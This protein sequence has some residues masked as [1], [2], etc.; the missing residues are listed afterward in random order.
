MIDLNKIEDFFILDLANNHFGDLEHAK[1]VINSFGQIIKK[2]DIDATIKLQFRN[3]D[4]YIHKSVNVSNSE[5]KY[6]ERF[7]STKLNQ[8]DFALIIKEIKSFGLKT[9]ST[10][11]DEDSFSL[12][13][14]LDIDIIKIASTS[15]N[16]QSLLNE[17]KKTNKPCVISVGGKDIEQIDEIV[18]FFEGFTKN[19]IIQHCVAVYPTPD[20]ELEL[21]QISLLKKRYPLIKIGYSTHEDPNN[22]DAIKIAYALGAQC[23]ERHIGV[24]SEKYKLNNYSSNPSQFEN[25][26]L[27]YKKAKNLLGAKNKKPISNS[28]SETLKKLARGVYAKEKIHKNDKL[29]KN[30][31]YFSFPLNEGQLSSNEFD[32]MKYISSGNLYKDEI[33]KSSKLIFCDEFE[34]NDQIKKVMLQFKSMI[35]HSKTFINPDAD[36]EISH[37]YG[38]Q[39]FREFG[40]LI[41]TCFNFEYAKKL[42]LLLPRQKHP[43]H[44][45]K[46]KKE[47]FQIL[48]GDL[49]AEVDGNRVNL[50]PGEICTVK[51]NQWH[52]FQTSNGVIFEEV[53]S[54]HY[55]NDSYYKDE[56]IAKMERSERKTNLGNWNTFFENL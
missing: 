56:K 6:V 44:F 26:I 37:H 33:I 28:E 17:V 7:K 31:V 15:A 43:Y 1:K 24:T 10:P 14:E 34:K 40:C 52:K 27:A 53:S 16:D 9:M 25:W 54:K 11:F 22:Y 3:L 30:N 45:H 4:S 8:N 32:E 19:F 18:N 46:K 23:F 35:K 49:E 29:S 5:N 2:L 38:M 36:I 47:T 48:F 50:E 42:I 13:D 55:N 39:K 41:I 12:I 51:T 21:N 20:E